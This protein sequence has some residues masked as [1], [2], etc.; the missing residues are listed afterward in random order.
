MKNREKNEGF[1]GLENQMDLFE[2]ESAKFTKMDKNFQD[3]KREKSGQNGG[4]LK[5]SD[6]EIIDLSSNLTSV[7]IDE[8]GYGCWAGPVFVCALQFLRPPEPIFRDSKSISAKKRQELYE[9][10]KEISR[11]KIGIGMIEEINEF[12]LGYAYKS[13][14]LR[15]VEPF[16]G[17]GTFFMD[18]RKPS[19]LDCYALVKGDQK[20]QAISAASIVAK[21]ER[22]AL[23]D[24]L[25][26]E[27]PMYKW[28]SNKGYGTAD[29][30]KAIREHGLCRW[31]RKSYNLDKYL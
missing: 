16:L 2:N 13:A 1:F 4:V 10:I 18:G 6:K 25:N 8:V 28:D 21:V 23:M 31:H 11:W 22:D 24:Q 27:F 20:I 5:L 3:E 17:Q 19:F 26:L 29:H 14:I 9:K 12:G 7:G 30:I 15:A